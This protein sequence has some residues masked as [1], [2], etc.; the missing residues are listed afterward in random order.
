M[1]PA[2]QPHL[3]FV[4]PN[5]GP[6]TTPGPEELVGAAIVRLQKLKFVVGVG[7][8]HDIHH[9]QHGIVEGLSGILQDMMR[10]CQT[11]RKDQ[12]T[13]SCFQDA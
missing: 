2:R 8:F 5:G 11:C 6:H 10:V 13:L 1:S 4:T 3:Q 9:P 7:P 12:L